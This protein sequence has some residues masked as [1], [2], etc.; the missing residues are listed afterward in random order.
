MVSQHVFLK[1][2]FLKMYFSKCISQNVT[3]EQQW[4]GSSQEGW[5]RWY[6]MAGYIAR[7]GSMGGYEC[8]TDGLRWLSPDYVH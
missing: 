6:L 1:M 4:K 5:S 7:D 3:T 8:G 2:Y